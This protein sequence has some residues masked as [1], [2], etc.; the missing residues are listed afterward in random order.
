MLGNSFS[1]EEEGL[2][3]PA[4]AFAPEGPV[5]TGRQL[6]TRRGASTAIAVSVRTEPPPPAGGIEQGRISCAAIAAAAPY[7]RHARRL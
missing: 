2:E 1:P 7:R 4:A 6:W 5:P 3:G